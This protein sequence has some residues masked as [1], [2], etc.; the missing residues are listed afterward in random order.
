[1]NPINSV[2]CVGRVVLCTELPFGGVNGVW[3]VGRADR[4]RRG[5]SLGVPGGNGRVDRAL[6]LA[7][8][9]EKDVRVSQHSDEGVA[10]CFCGSAWVG[11]PSM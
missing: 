6:V 3:S 9:V 8:A 2:A 11:G 4:R 1:M 10:G 5:G 7:A